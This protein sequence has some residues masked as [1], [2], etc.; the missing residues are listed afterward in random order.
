SQQLKINEFESCQ[1]IEPDGDGFVVTTEQDKNKLRQQYR[2]RRAIL[3]IGN[4]GTPMRLPV[5]GEELNIE[6]TP[7]QPVLPAFCDKCG[8]RRARQSKFCRECGK[9]YDGSIPPPYQDDKVKYRLSDPNDFHGKHCLVVGAGN[10]AV[11]AAIDLAAHR[12]ADGAGITGWRDN[13]VTLV[14]RSDFK[15]D[16]KFGNKLLAYECIDAGKITAHFRTVVK[17]VTPTEVV[18]MDARERDPRTAS[19]KERLKNDYVFALIGGDKPTKFLESI[20]IKIG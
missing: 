2:A 17:E 8:T 1:S 6:V 9:Q 20:G 13:T 5:P 11:E 7:T 14:I 10:S 18:L 4:R 19:E 12:S 15:G 16:L 3:A